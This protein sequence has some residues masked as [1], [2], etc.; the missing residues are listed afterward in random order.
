MDGPTVRLPADLAE[1]LDRVAEG[2][3]RSR[4]NA[5]QVLIL[6]SLR[7]REAQN[8]DMEESQ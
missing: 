5:A 6:E 3:L 1:R 7:R 4:N 2:E 8:L